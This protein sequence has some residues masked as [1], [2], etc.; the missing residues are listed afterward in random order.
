MYLVL[1]E[2][3][4]LTIDLRIYRISLSLLGVNAGSDSKRSSLLFINWSRVVASEMPNSNER[5]NP[6]TAKSFKLEFS[7]NWS[8]RDPLL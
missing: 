6:L 2:D 7:L 3:R 4:S 5:I 8:W 1:V